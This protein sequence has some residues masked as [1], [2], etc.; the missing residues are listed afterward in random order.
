MDERFREHERDDRPDRDATRPRESDDT[1]DVARRRQDQ[2]QRPALT[3][4]E[5]EERWPIG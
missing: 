5:R 4:R 1:S 2:G 3:R